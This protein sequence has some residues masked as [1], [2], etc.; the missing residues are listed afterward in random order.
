MA[1]NVPPAEWTYAN[2]EY[3]KQQLNTGS[4]CN[5]WSREVKTCTPEYYRWEQWLFTKLFNKGVIYKRTSTVNSYG[6]D[7]AG[8]RAEKANRRAR[9]AFRRAGGTALFAGERRRGQEGQEYAS[10]G[11]DCTGSTSVHGD[12]MQRWP[13]FHL[14]FRFEILCCTIRNTD[15]YWYTR[16]SLQR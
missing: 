12:S 5:R 2:I 9:L 3:M 10:A 16:R 4:A 1:H 6:G 15:Y 11:L 13:R 14:E 7:C 8:E